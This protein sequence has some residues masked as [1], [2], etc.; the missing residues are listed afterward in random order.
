MKIIIGST[1]AQLPCLPATR[2]TKR[3]TA[4]VVNGLWLEKK[5]VVWTHKHYRRAKLSYHSTGQVL[6]FR[7]TQ[8]NIITIQQQLSSR[9]HTNVSRQLK[10]CSRRRVYHTSSYVWLC[11]CEFELG[12]ASECVIV[13]FWCACVIL[14]ARWD[15]VH[16]ALDLRQEVSQTRCRE[17]LRAVMASS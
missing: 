10:T 8:L 15:S 13:H 9:L 5:K 11:A 1:F 2:F 14:W 12:C 3:K 16:T 17:A 7:C 4:I 6:A